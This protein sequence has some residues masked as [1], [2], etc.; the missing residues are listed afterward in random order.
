M[1]L[2]I[3]VI[4]LAL[5]FD[6]INGFHDAANAIATVV[7]TRVL[8]PTQAVIWAAFFN[9]IA[10]LVFGL[11]VA[12]TVGKG[13]VHAEVVTLHTILS[14]L[15]AAIAWNLITWWQGIPSS[16]SH[17]LIGGFVGAAIA[18]SGWHAVF[19]SEVFKIIAF[20]LLAP[21]IGM[22]ISMILS[23]LLLNIFKRSN[24]DKTHRLFRR[25]QLLSAAAYS[26]GHGGNDAQKTMGIIFVAL[27][28]TGHLQTNDS[29][30]LWIVLSCHGAMAVG[31]LMGGWRIVK[32]MGS[33]ITHLTPFE[34][35]SAETAGAL[36]LFGTSALGIPVST[37]HTIA[38][39]IMGAG[40][41]HR[42]SAVRWGVTRNIFISW[43]ITI[44]ITAV[45]AAAIQLL[46]GW[47]WS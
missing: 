7:T 13:I 27:V 32:T 45:A 25:L 12:E 17:T 28:T 23:F 34:G 16:S 47:L 21:L 35:F 33:R 46:S 40:A 15:S 20:I 1:V 18:H 5:A 43:V 26:L 30:P 24:P 36:T 14:G 4:G 42:L 3:I 44:P 19:Y 29:I 31:T 41:T 38:G 9:F 39:A 8:S 22:I 37:T 10:Y 11:H 2:L 6:T